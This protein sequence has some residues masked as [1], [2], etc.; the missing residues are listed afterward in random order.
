MSGLHGVH[1]PI[2]GRGAAWPPHQP[3]EAVLCACRRPAERL[4]CSWGWLCR[5]VSASASFTHPFAS[6]PPPHS[7]LK[8]C[9]LER[10]QRSRSW[11][12]PTSSDRVKW[13]RDRVLLPKTRVTQGQGVPDHQGCIRTAVHRTPGGRTRG[14]PP[15]QTPYRP[16]LPFRCLRLTAQNMLRRLRRQ[17]D[18]G[19]KIFGPPSAGTIGAPWEK[20]VPAKPPSPPSNAS[21]QITACSVSGAVPS[22]LHGF[23]ESLPGQPGGAGCRVG[24]GG[25]EGN[26]HAAHP[27]STTPPP[28]SQTHTAPRH[29]SA[30]LHT[31]QPPGRPSPSPTPFVGWYRPL[32]PA[33]GRYGCGGGD[34]LGSHWGQGSPRHSGTRDPL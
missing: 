3:L 1:Y 33:R 18:L 27:Q 11:S 15:P 16:L 13:G 32:C 2:K 19:F 22:Q 5:A 31:A 20:K 25:R 7:S 12:W 10:V 26:A 4:M 6:S 14:V 17:E 23:W 21:L 24:S 8:S 34:L 28:P 9:A 29:T 30:R